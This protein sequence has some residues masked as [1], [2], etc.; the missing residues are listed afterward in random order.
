MADKPIAASKAVVIGLGSMGYG[1]ARSI[2]RAGMT[3]WGFDI[4]PEREEK[5][6]ADGGSPGARPE[7]VRAADLVVSVVVNESQTE[8]VLFGENG[9][10]RHM[11][12]GSVFVSCATVSPA[13]ARKM[14]A[15]LTEYEIDYLDAPVSGGT[16]RA[17]AGEL[18]IMAS[19]A[20]RAFEK[21]RPVL[22]AMARSIFRMGEEP[23]Q[24]SAMK[25]VNQLLAGV[26]IVAAAEAVTFGISQGIDP[27]KALEVI[28]QS[29]GTSWMF[30]NRVPHIVAGDYTPHSNVDIFVKDLGIVSEVARQSKFSA[31]LAAAALQ[32][33]VAASGAGLGHEDDSAV[34]KIYAQNAGLALPEGI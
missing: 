14:A 1:M 29:A 27:R 25:I 5:F 24:G 4:A 16:E 10:V 33:F 6:R 13:F 26:H 19:G 7:A 17:A 2:L 23:G 31:P 28:T 12:P 22:E 30:E 20:E 15:R 21:A 8:D 32:Q 11:N 3:V 9:F 34:A 18:S